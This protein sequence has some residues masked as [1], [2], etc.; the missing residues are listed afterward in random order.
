MKTTIGN[1]KIGQIF[2]LYREG[3][4]LIVIGN[5]ID[6]TFGKRIICRDLNGEKAKYHH[7]CVAVIPRPPKMLK[8]KK[9]LPVA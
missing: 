2:I 4:P 6:K 3:M 1:L 7:S 9:L 5:E 8:R